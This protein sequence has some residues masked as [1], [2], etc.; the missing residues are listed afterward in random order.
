M[1][2]ETDDR[3][4]E[5]VLVPVPKSRVLEVYGLLARQPVS[6]DTDAVRLREWTPALLQRTW[7]ESPEPLKQVLRLLKERAG[8]AVLIDEL[9]LAALGSGDAAHRKKLGGMLS[10]L[11]KR[12]REY[13][14]TTWPFV[15]RKNPDAGVPEYSMPESI[16]ER[17][18]GL[19]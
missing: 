5:F 10:G 11:T 1:M 4:D 8:Q 19:S 6:D 17:H 13:G 2:Q 9:A 12:T 15:V 18:D 7:D 14:A 16:A 3:T